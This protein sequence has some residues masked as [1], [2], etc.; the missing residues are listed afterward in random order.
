MAPTHRCLDPLHTGEN[1]PSLGT[2]QHPHVRMTDIR[3][4]RMAPW[5]LDPPPLM[6]ENRVGTRRKGPGGAEDSSLPVFTSTG[7]M[8]IG[9]K[10]KKSQTQLENRNTECR[11][12][13]HYGNP[14]RRQMGSEGSGETPAQKRGPSSCQVGSERPGNGQGQPTDGTSEDGPP[15]NPTQQLPRDNT[16]VM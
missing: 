15:T 13:N 3:E 7:M 11:Q 10:G 12:E 16:A 2:I 8:V 4:D 6:S 9:K 1:Q 5:D 14:R